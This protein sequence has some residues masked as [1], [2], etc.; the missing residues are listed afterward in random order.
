MSPSV[1]ERTVKADGPAAATEFAGVVPVEFAVVDEGVDV[2]VGR[3]RS[4]DMVVPGRGIRS[5]VVVGNPGG[6]AAEWS[7]ALLVS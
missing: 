5:A 1:M 7:V 4:V 2:V 6:E 3:I